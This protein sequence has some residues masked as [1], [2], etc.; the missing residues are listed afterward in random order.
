[1]NDT[2]RLDF[3]KPGFRLLA[4]DHVIQV[5]WLDGKESQSVAVPVSEGSR[6]AIDAAI[7]K[8]GA[9]N[10]RILAPTD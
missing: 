10:E 3:I 8:Q 7:T 6:A 4:S 2:Q 1:M 5:W 9:K